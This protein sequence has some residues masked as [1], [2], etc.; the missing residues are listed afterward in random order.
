M[1]K[2]KDDSIEVPWDRMTIT[3]PTPK[4]KIIRF[5]SLIEPDLVDISVRLDNE[6]FSITGTFKE[7]EDD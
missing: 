4:E 5:L 3:K 2:N 6:D 1:A 7:N